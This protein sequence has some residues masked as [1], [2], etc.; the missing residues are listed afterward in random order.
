MGAH[1]AEAGRRAVFSA[2]FPRLGRCQLEVFCHDRR[3]DLTVRSARPLPDEV[4]R[5]AAVLFLA[6][7]DLGGLRGDISFAPGAL[8][9]LPERPEPGGVRSLTA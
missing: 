4:R 9:D 1:A 3:F 8:L 5:T 2:D 7:R 6:A